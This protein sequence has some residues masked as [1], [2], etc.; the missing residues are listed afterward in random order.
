[1]RT[2]AVRFKRVHPAARLPMRQTESAAGYDLYAC[3]DSRLTIARG[4]IQ[5]VPTGLA[6]AIPPGFH[7]SIRARSGMAVRHGLTPIN[8]PGT[9]D[10]DYRGEIFVPL[11]NLGSADYTIE[12][13]DRI[14]QLVIEETL[15]IDWHEGELDT[16]ARG[17]GK[18]GSTGKR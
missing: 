7:I 15:A 11:I 8:T 5:P 17:E 12:H 1:M 2:V 9:I 3:L 6:V 10:A 18:F 14:A 4:S 16:T 13:G